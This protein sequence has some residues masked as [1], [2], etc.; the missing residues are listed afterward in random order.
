MKHN[1]KILLIVLSLFVFTQ[2][3]GLYVVNYY[4]PT[5]VVDNYQQNVTS[6]NQLPFGLEPPPVNNQVNIWITLLYILPAF[7]IAI[8]IFFVLSRLKAEIILKGWFFLVM[9]IALSVSL[10]SF[11]PGFQYAWIVALA[12]AAPLIFLRIYKKNIILHN[13]TET[14]IY[15]G[16]AA[17]FVALLSTPENPNRGVYSMIA[18]LIIIS[19]YDMWAVWHSGI[20]QKMAKFQINKLRIFGGFFVPYVSK[21]MRDKIKKM[22][23]T[24][25]GREKKIR[26]NFALLGGG[27]VVFPMIMS[28]VVLR[29][30]GFA[31]IFG[32]NLPAA[33]LLIILGAVLGLSGL[34]IFGK[35]KP[36][37][38]MPFISLGVF[39][40]L[41]ACYLIFG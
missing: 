32:I 13:I 41:G 30:F 24:K 26:I 9:T 11:I 7:A 19:F 35:K 37:P 17:I 34:L 15:P 18:L 8:V 2:L 23:K 39:A 4:S 28:G 21:K 3:V 16:I 38:A 14:L 6:P 25:K 1:P 29:R 12:I 27:D 10:I 22:K 5:V 36:Y 40:A 31:G 33:S 20:M